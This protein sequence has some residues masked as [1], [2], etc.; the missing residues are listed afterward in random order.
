MENQPMVAAAPPVFA[1]NQQRF[2]LSAVDPSITLLHFLRHH[3]SFK[4][5]KLGCGEGKYGA[6]GPAHLI[7]VFL[8]ETDPSRAAASSVFPSPILELYAPIAS[9]LLYELIDILL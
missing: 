9:A 3:T 4:S 6:I 1:V 2:E 7:R 5:V 8:L